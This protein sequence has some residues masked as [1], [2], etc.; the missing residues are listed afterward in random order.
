MLLRATIVFFF[1][2]S[3]RTNVKCYCWQHYILRCKI[4]F[5][6]V[7]KSSYGIGISQESNENHCG[8]V[9][10]HYSSLYFLLNVYQFAVTLHHFQKCKDGLTQGT[11]YI[12]TEP[13]T[14]VRQAARTLSDHV[15][16]QTDILNN[17]SFNLLKGL[18][19]NGFS[20]T[21]LYSHCSAW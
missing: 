19:G 4:N 17:G 6:L 1:F 11:E 18:M 14:I 12:K 13:K 16:C 21:L 9:T 3:H 7:A 20:A 10:V 2:V 8:W 15:A 5:R